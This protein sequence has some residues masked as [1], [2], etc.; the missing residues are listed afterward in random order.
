MLKRLPACPVQFKTAIEGLMKEGVQALDGGDAGS[1][2]KQFATRGVPE[3]RDGLAANKSAILGF[4]LQAILGQ[5]AGL[6]FLPIAGQAAGIASGQAFELRLG[7]SAQ[8]VGGD[9]QG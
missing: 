8:Q 1:T 3:E 9:I 2:D 4:L 5:L 7:V 6:A